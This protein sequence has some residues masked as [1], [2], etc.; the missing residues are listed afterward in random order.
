MV[1]ILRRRREK[2]R[3]WK[4]R[5]ATGLNGRKNSDVALV[6]LHQARPLWEG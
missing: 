2:V 4:E 5:D 1:D 3:E 6:A